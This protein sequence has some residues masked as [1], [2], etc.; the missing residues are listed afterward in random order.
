LALLISAIPFFASFSINTT[1]N[2]SINGVVESSSS[3]MDYVAVIAGSI[4]AV[5]GI[6]AV[7]RARKAQRHKTAKIAGIA[8]LIGAFHLVKAL[9]F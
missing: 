1:R 5:L 2:T 7:L 8:I 6:R 9:L 3:G 4:G